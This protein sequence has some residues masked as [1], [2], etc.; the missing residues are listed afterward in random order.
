PTAE[1]LKSI[2]DSKQWSHLLHYRKHP[3]TGRYI[4]QNDSPNFFLAENGKSS[5]SAE[6]KT[7]LQQFLV[8]DLA[9]N[10]S[11]QCKFPARY[12]WIKKQLPEL[13]FVDQS[14]S[15]L[16]EWRAQLS[17]ESLTLVFPASHI[18]SPSS[19]YGHT[20]IRLD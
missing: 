7:D 20:F 10:Q 1:K 6:L 3:F 14:C 4:S 11:A 13:N 18:I 2:S 9:D 12:N 15:E 17:A 16:E 8:T 5:L 19:M